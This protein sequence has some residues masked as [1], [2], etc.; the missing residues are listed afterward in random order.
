M[1]EMRNV[2]LLPVILFF[3][4]G[5]LGELRA[6]TYHESQN[7]PIYTVRKVLGCDRLDDGAR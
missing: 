6:R 2:P 3:F 4:M 1:Q 7:K 5:L